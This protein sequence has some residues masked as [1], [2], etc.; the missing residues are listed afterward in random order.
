MRS[1]GSIVQ[2]ALPGI[3]AA[4]APSPPAIL[5]GTLTLYQLY[6]IGDAID[7]DL[8]QACLAAPGAQR[9]APVPARPPA[10]IQTA[11]PP[12]RIALGPTSVA[13]GG[14]AFAGRLRASI[15][16]L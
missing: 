15:Y 14:L 2:T 13:L 16:D 3:N 9:R 5:S 10:S 11:Q 4:A 12:L 1:E 7:L 8:A 6:D